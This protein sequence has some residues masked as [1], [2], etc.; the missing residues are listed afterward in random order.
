MC[1]LAGFFNIENRISSGDLLATAG[2]MGDTLVHRGPDDSGVWCSEHRGVAFA[3]QRLSIVDLSAAG[4]QPMS[5]INGRMTIAYNGEIYNAPEIRQKL[6]TL[7]FTFRGGSDTEV[8]LAACEHWGVHDAVPKFIGM[9][10]FALWDTA[11]QCL[12]LCRDRMGIKPLYWSRQNGILYFGSELKAL[13][14]HPNFKRG[15]DNSAIASFLRHNY[16]PGPLTIYKDVEKLSPGNILCCN[17]SGDI[18]ITP[19]WTLDDAVS[20]GR[21]KAFAGSDEEAIAGLEDVLSDAVS[22]RMVADVSLGAFLSGGVDSSLI[23]SLMQKQ[24]DRPVKTFSI[25]FEEAEFNESVYA[26]EV[27]KHLG[28]DHTNLIVSEKMALDIVPSLSNTFDEPFSDSSQ[29]PTCLLSK[30]TKEHVTVALSGD[31]GDELFAGYP[32]YSQ[33]ERYARLLLD[34]PAY[35]R[36]L[37]ALIIRSVSPTVWNQV[38]KLLPKKFRTALSGDKLIRLPAVLETGNPDTLYRSMVSHADF[39][40]DIMLEGVEVPAPIWSKRHP[41]NDDDFLSHMQYLDTLTYLPDDILTKVDRA[42][43]SSS[44]EAR[45]PMIDHR[46]VEYSWK[47]PRKFKVRDGVDKW[48]LK[49][50]LYK[51]VPP[52]LI[53]RPKMGFGVPLGQWILGDLREWSEDLLSESSLKATG[54]LKVKPVRKKW[55]EHKSGLVNWQ[56]PIWDILMLQSWILNQD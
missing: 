25:G 11:S 24:S 50:L 16:I 46:V 51:H 10:A 39:P 54:V 19:F 9:F 48:V 44:L 21:N 30:L 38:T 37:A 1:G 41:A 34:H 23:A 8:L 45:V 52:A 55:D 18:D 47:L 26:T 12:Y 6:L 2:A 49:Q 42:S 40:E 56:Y 29:I 17:S 13:K 15:I 22:R 14:A 32:R 3:H 4:A 7:G 5:T 31:G 33:C 27:A 28:T 53:D 20:D 35:A 43:M 36:K